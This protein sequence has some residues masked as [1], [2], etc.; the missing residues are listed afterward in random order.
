MKVT[1]VTIVIYSVDNIKSIK[2]NDTKSKIV[3]L[4]SQK[5]ISGEIA[6]VSV[7]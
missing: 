6:I 2:C 3:A 7:K 4:F 5:K 1:N